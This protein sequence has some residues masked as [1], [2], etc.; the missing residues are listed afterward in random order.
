MIHDFLCGDG[1]DTVLPTF[2]SYCYS[3]NASQA[4]EKIATDEKKYRKRS[5]SVK[6]WMTTAY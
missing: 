6:V 3:A 4:V 5:L 1:F 2:R